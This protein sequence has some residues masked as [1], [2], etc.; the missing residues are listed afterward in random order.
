MIRPALAAFLAALA[1]APAFAVSQD[2]DRKIA[3]GLA[4]GYAFDFEASSAAFSEVDRLEP[5]NPAGPFFLA[6][7]T[8]FEFT[9][10]LDAPGADGE[11]G[12]RFDAFID[13]ALRRA[14]V[15]RGKDD[16]DAQASFFLGAA[17]GMR[18]RWK[19]TKR[20][21][22]RAAS[23]G[24]KAYKELKRA[25]ALDP[26]CYDAYLGLGMYDYYSDTL[27][28]VLKIASK[29]I[30]R[31]DKKRGLRYIEAAAANGRY[32][33]IEA[34]LFL[35]G[36]YNLYEKAPEKA[37]E[38]V[39]E[40]R[41]DHPDN[42]FFLYMEASARIRARDWTGAV[43]LGERLAAR[44]REVS[45]TAPYVSLFD[46]ALA[47]AYLGGRDYPNALRAAQACVLR[48]PEPE[49]WN[50]T[51]CRLRRAQALDLLGRRGDAVEDYAAVRRRP[52]Y[53]D[54]RRKARRG[55]AG[56]ATEAIVLE[57]LLE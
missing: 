44:G 38:V 41:Q 39:G 11:L 15:L 50:V 37:L 13:E 43:A 25:V 30:V 36:I 57:E 22:V 54:S 9:L 34:R 6:S 51:Y 28:S 1:A 21:W 46:R 3:E 35:A 45:F 18:G 47:E 40:L 20:Q 42:L 49:S 16:N 23:D 56:P 31:G 2:V 24:W 14:R 4:A 55:L 27:P 32:S 29:L 8:W 5:D 52:D 7:L 12:P 19:I 33:A 48:A 10:N 17:Y 53:W 26:A